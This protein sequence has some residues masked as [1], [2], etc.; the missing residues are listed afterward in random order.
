MPSSGDD[1][2][3]SADGGDGGDG[4]GLSGVRDHPRWCDCFSV[5]LIIH[6]I[7]IAHK[8]TEQ[9]GSHFGFPESRQ[10]PNL[11]K[12]TSHDAYLRQTNGDTFQAGSTVHMH[13]LSQLLGF[14]SLNE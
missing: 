10:V 11:P 1:A 2:D 9:V 3:D 12:I 5:H 8:G 4:G 13:P 6:F 7:S 14:F